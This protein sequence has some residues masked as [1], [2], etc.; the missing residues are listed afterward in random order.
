MQKF[1][2]DFLK[3]LFFKFQDHIDAAIRWLSMPFK[4]LQSCSE[5][6]HSDGRK[7]QN[8]QCNFMIAC[9]LIDNTPVPVSQGYS[10]RFRITGIL[11]SDKEWKFILKMTSL[12]F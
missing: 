4:N 10:G 9:P 12:I 7:N 6:N 3:Q 5:K 8:R 11:H 2:N 1:R